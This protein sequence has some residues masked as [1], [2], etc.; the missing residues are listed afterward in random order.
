MDNI[1]EIS[2]LKKYYG[3]VKAVDDI[4]FSVERGTL[5]AFLGINGAGKST[6]INI[7]CNTLQK[8]SGKVTIDGFDIDKNSEKIKAQIGI[9]FQ[10][11][12]LDDRLTVKDNL[13]IRASYY[14]L[15]GA[16]WAKRLKELTALL[17]LEEILNRPYGKLSG[18]QRRRVDIARGLINCPKL[19]FLDEPTTGLDP[20][21]R[22]SVWKVINTLRAEK[23]MT[24][25]LTTH[26]MEEANE[27]NNV[28]ILDC[29]KI[30]ACDTPNNLKN[31][32]SGDYIKIYQNRSEEFDKILSGS[33]Y[34][35]TYD[36]NRYIIK[37]PDSKNAKD[38]IINHSSYINDFEVVKGDMDDVFLN[39]T[40]K[41]LEG[42][43]L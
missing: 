33:R 11:S 24:V 4:S 6:T 27:A 43:I 12:V 21:T 16:E 30:V 26:Y 42:G 5:F 36:T 29:G 3:N 34:G 25:F 37:M 35:S 19:L 32:Y 20:K 23:D 13:S 15:R 39:A 31:K 2:N 7:L 1:I 41:T 18:G 14:A 22:Q 9:V 38:F 40:G 8:D 28:V 10:N 17:E